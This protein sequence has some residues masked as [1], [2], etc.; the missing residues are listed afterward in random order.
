MV[1]V[2]YCQ[3]VNQSGGQ[4]QPGRRSNHSAA[5]SGNRGFHKPLTATEVTCPLAEA[6][7][8]GDDNTGA[9]AQLDRKLEEQNAAAPGAG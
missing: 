9:Q 7:I 6:E 1:A 3:P 5:V 8:D 4:F 2:V